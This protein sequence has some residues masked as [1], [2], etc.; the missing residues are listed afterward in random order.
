MSLTNSLYS[1]RFNALLTSSST[2]VV[3]CYITHPSALAF[4]TT[5]L[6]SLVYLSTLDSCLPSASPTL[7][8]TLSTP[9]VQLTLLVA[10]TTV[11]L[12]YVVR[13]HL[14]L[15]LAVYPLLESRVELAQTA[16][17]A[18]LLL[19]ATSVRLL[20]QVLLLSLLTV[21]LASLVDRLLRLLRVESI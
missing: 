3:S 9:V 12:P 15:F 19:V 13:S 2:L 17:R 18:M 11:L 7:R 1:L 16:C 6:L 14:L 20:I 8:P 21:L 4:A 5:L 10:L